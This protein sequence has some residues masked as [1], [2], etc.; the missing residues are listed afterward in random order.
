M[1][2]YRN[3]KKNIGYK[4]FDSAV[5]TDAVKNLPNTLKLAIIFV[6]KAIRIVVEFF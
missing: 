3:K 5:I 1:F 2:N 6:T 4:K